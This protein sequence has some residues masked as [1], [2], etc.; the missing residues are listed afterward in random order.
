MKKNEDP[1]D[2]HY[3]EMIDSVK[4][5]IMNSFKATQLES[6]LAGIEATWQVVNKVREIEMNKQNSVKV[7]EVQNCVKNNLEK[8]IWK[9]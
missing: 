8:H 3:D 7:D 9:V 6:K 5:S 4:L 1:T 2:E